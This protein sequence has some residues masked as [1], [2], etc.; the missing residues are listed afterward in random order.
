MI[1]PRST[2]LLVIGAGVIGL[3]IAAEAV[4]SGIETLVVTDAQTA[5][6]RVSAASFGCINIH[7]K[8]PAAYIRLHQRAIGLH[9]DLNGRVGD[10]SRWLHSIGAEFFGEHHPEWGYV[11]ADAYARAYEA[12]ILTG[13][14]R[15]LRGVRVHSIAPSAECPG[16][17]GGTT[18]SAAPVAGVIRVDTSAG[19]IEAARV[20]LA[21]GA[22]TAALLPDA[23][24]TARLATTEG[25]RGFL[26]RVRADSPV[27]H[28]VVNHD[29]SIRPDGEGRFAV[30]SLALELE[31]AQE[32]RRASLATVRGRLQQRLREHYGLA[33]SEDAFFAV[34]EA[35]RPLPVD[36]LPVVGWLAPSLYVAVSHSGFNLAPLLGRAAV[37][38]LAGTPDHDFDAFRPLPTAT[39]PVP[40][41]ATASSAS[42][43]AA[44][45]A[46]TP[47]ATAPAASASARPA[48]TASTPASSPAA[49]ASARA[50]AADGPDQ[51]RP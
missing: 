37:R 9:R 8:H 1:R 21:T 26:A 29:L 38:E 12:A 39:V 47:A 2:A 22:G 43:T 4:A 13:G 11:D 17:G 25:P 44:S 10:G 33:L 30:Q 31:L 46:S 18:A 19:P 6:T 14:G 16:P 36:G 51:G 35:A 7:E 20:V 49:T 32:G 40:S 3:S 50:T 24:R 45:T 48:G 27:D 28:V 34:D 42:A 5:R 41:T 15:I 23:L